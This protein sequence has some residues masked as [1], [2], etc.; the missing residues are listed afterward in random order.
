MKIASERKQ[1]I[2][3]TPKEAAST[4]S[5]SIQTHRWTGVRRSEIVRV[6]LPLEPVNLHESWSDHR[7]QGCGPRLRG[8]SK[9]RGKAVVF[10]F[11]VPGLGAEKRNRTSGLGHAFPDDRGCLSPPS[12]ASGRVFAGVGLIVRCGDNGVL[13]RV[14]EILGRLVDRRAARKC[15]GRRRRLADDRI[16]GTSRRQLLLNGF[17]T[18][19]RVFQAMARGGPFRRRRPYDRRRLAHWRTV[20]SCARFPTRISGWPAPSLTQGC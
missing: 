19:S 8:V 2:P 7:D 17:G 13:R 9:E 10:T 14:V 3:S 12:R 16:A 18:G 11:H 5:S 4:Q 1:A 6:S 15:R 20:V